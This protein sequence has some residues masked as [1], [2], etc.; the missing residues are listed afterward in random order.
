MLENGYVNNEQIVFGYLLKNHEE[1]FECYE[2][3]NWKQIAL[4]LE[5]SK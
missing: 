3:E 2:R 5:L 1:L 4:F